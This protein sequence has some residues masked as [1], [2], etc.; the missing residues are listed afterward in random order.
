MEIYMWIWNTD[1]VLDAVQQPANPLPIADFDHGDDPLVDNLRAAMQQI[2]QIND[3]QAR[4]GAINQFIDH[5]N[6]LEGP[7]GGVIH[8]VQVGIIGDNIQN[9]IQQTVG[10]VSPGLGQVIQ[11][12]VSVV[13]QGVQQGIALSPPVPVAP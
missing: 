5:P 12:A 11:T 1:A 13:Q 7:Q 8:R 9:S 6:L 2:D 4:L 3:P 10:L